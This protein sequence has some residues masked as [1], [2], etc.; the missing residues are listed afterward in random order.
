MLSLVLDTSSKFLYFSFLENEKVIYEKF[1]EGKNDHSDNLLKEISFG[2]KEINLE[3]KDFNRI[4]V[5]KGP[6]SYTG[7]RVSMTVA[8]MLSWSLNIPLY[9]TSSLSLLASN[10]LKTDGIYAITM[11]A[12]K[13]H[14]YGKLIIVENS[15]CEVVIDDLFLEES[16]YFELIKIYSYKLV[17][18]NNYA[19]NPNNVELSK[20]EDLHSLTP[21]Y[22]QRE[23]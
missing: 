5:G 14:V 1:L 20:V 10:Y 3:I 6:G 13:Q 16:K 9:T 15:K 7:L 22:I 12:K 8:K 2:L 17:N 4:I 21:N 19:I 18:E 23:I 11:R